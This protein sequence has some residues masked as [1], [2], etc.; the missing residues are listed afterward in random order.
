MWRLRTFGESL[1]NKSEESQKPSVSSDYW[2]KLVCAGPAARSEELSSLLLETGTL[3]TE[4]QVPRGGTD[5]EVVSI[6][7]YYS[8]ELSPERRGEIES[9]LT[10]A[11]FEVVVRWEKVFAENWAENWKDFFPPI[12]VGTLTVVPPWLAEDFAGQEGVLVI[13]PGM[14]FGTGHHPT[15]EGCLQLLQKVE[16]SG[17]SVLDVGTGS[18]ILSLASVLLGA[19]RAFGLDIDP[20]SIEASREN[21]RRNNLEG[22]VEFQLTSLEE[23]GGTYHLAIANIQLN[24][25]RGLAPLFGPRLSAEGLLILSGILDY[26]VSELLKLYSSVGFSEIDRVVSGEWVSLL[27]KLENS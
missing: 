18:G 19:E 20:A 11:G 10:G 21:A 12:R 14:A 5:S 22:R 6:A 23:V 25:L 4:E 15:T 1:M 16:L 13:N 8:P 2:F 24:V 3:G 26:Q 17:K 7:A 27:L 9:F